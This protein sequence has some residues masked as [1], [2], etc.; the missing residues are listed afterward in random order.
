MHGRRGSTFQS[1]M[2]ITFSKEDVEDIAKSVW[3]AVRYHISQNLQR[4]SG[5]EI[6][7]RKLRASSKTDLE[8]VVAYLNATMSDGKGT[9]FGYVVRVS[10]SFV[11][12]HL[13]LDVLAMK[14]VRDELVRDG[15]LRVIR[16]KSRLTL[17]YTRQQQLPAST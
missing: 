7:A 2:K 4:R 9:R 11:A 17:L 16:Q 12:K 5:D 3:Q 6:I 15:R 13:G 1:K 8:K 14:R 10:N